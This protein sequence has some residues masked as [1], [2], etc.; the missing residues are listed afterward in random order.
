MAEREE[1]DKTLTYHPDPKQV[2]AILANINASIAIQAKILDALKVDKVINLSK[3]KEGR[4]IAARF[5][6]VKRAM[7]AKG[8]EATPEALAER[9]GVSVSSVHEALPYIDATMEST[10]DL[11]LADASESI[12][13]IVERKQQVEAFQVIV[14][15]Y[16]SRCSDLERE[17]LDCHLLQED[18]VP[19]A[20]LGARNGRTKQR[21]CQI[22]T[23]VQKDLQKLSQTL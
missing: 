1:Q 8:E 6:K 10:D 11:P 7:E 2:A 3:G 21:M 18:P 19:L 15:V 12:A 13:S 14:E 4:K 5:H 22:K 9:I 23:K 16:R 17:V 20:T